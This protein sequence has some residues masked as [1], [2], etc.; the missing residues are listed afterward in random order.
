MAETL[1]IDGGKPVRNEPLPPPYPGALLMGEEEKRAVLEIIEHKAPFRYYGPDVLKKVSQFERS[2]ERY[3]EINHALG[4]SSGTAGVKVALVALGVGPG[5][6]VIVPA[7]TFIA[8]VSAVV[9]ARAVPIFVEV[10]DSLNIDPYDLR[11]KISPRTKAIMVVHLQGVSCDMDAVVA[12]ADSNGVAVLE[13]CAQSFGAV[14]KGRKVGAFGK[15]GVFSLQ[16]NK[17]ITAGEG[18]CVVTNDR[19]LFHRA[20]RCHDHGNL[21]EF[22]GGAPLLGENYR[23]SELAGAVAVVQLQKLEDLV[24]KMTR[25]KQEIL[26]GIGDVAGITFRRIPDGAEDLGTSV[27]FF[28]PSAKTAAD[29]VKALNGE[30]INSSQ[31]YGGAVYDAYPQVLNM[32]TATPEGCPFTCP[33]YDGKVR[34]YH[35]M[36]PRTEAFA[37]RLIYIPLAPTFEDREI[38][39]VVI[40]VRKVAAHV[41]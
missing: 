13:D 40:G 2:V 15:M 37:R 4:V 12:I 28:T 24:A 30:N 17:L 5:D 26:R 23:M 14:Y 35:G 16:I 8:C 25:V 32:S 1:A 33:Y 6:E 41:L 22:E 27:M 9:A 3:L 19:D 20:V 11:D 39:D 21:R 10:D 7:Y 36:C 29:F 34:Y 31:M 38:A 18:G